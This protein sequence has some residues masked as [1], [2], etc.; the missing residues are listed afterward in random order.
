MQYRNPGWTG[1]APHTLN[2]TDL[3]GDFCSFC[4]C[5]SGFYRF[6][7]PISQKGNILFPGEKQKRPTESKAMAVASTL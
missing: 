7:G 5:N 2:L 3:F 6:Q 1:V 4:F